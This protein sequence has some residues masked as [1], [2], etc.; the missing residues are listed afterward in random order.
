MGKVARE[1]GELSSRRWSLSW[2]GW[3]SEELQNSEHGGGRV[4]S[5]LLSRPDWSLLSSGLLCS[6]A[7]CRLPRLHRVLAVLSLSPPHPQS[8]APAS[9][10]PHTLRRAPEG[11]HALHA[12]RWLPPAPGAADP[13]RPTAAPEPHPRA[14]PPRPYPRR[15][16]GPRP[17]RRG[18]HRGA[19]LIPSRTC[20]LAH[21]DTQPPRPSPRSG[22]CTE[23]LGGWSRRTGHAQKPGLAL[24][25]SRKL[26]HSGGSGD[27][28]ES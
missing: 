26:L 16:A 27:F 12:P 21:P 18:A 8:G 24:V 7:R 14:F 11:Y 23:T 10:R 15:A 19:A 6:E 13:D 1:K 2:G 20:C 3:R 9:L 4:R 22:I 25:S 5:V 28:G 17:P